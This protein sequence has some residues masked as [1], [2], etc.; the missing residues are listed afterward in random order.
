MKKIYPLIVLLGLVLMGQAVMGQGTLRGRVTDQGS[1]EPLAGAK[2]FLPGGIAGGLSDD[3]G[4]FEFQVPQ[5][6]PFDVIVTFLGYDTLRTNVTDL[7]KPVKLGMREKSV[8]VQAVEIVGRS[9]SEKEQQ[10]P[11]TVES[12]GSI[13][14]KE[15]AGADFYGSLGNLKGV[16]L[17]SASLGF[18]IINTRGFNSTSPV[19]SLQII[20]GVDNQAPGLNFSL[21]NFLGSS[22]LDL[23]KVDLIVGASSAYYGPNAFNGVIS[24]NTKNPF[25]HQGL[26]VQAKVGERA[27]ADVALRYAK[28]FK[29]KND[30]EIFAFKI[31]GAFMRANDWQATNV[32]PTQQSDRGM[33]NP[34]GYDKV[35][36]Y[37]DENLTR[38]INNFS[39]LYAQRRYPGLDIYYRDGYREQDIVNYNTYNVKLSGALHFKVLKGAELVMGSNFGTGSTVYQGDNRYRLEDI[40]F[41]QH[42]IELKKEDKYFIRS[43]FTHEDGG[44]SYDAVTTAFYI[45]DSAKN[46]NDW[47]TDYAYYWITQIK[48]RVKALPGFPDENIFPYDTAAANAVMA[49]YPDS[50]DT[51]HQMARDYANGVTPTTDSRDRFL[52]GTAQFDSVKNYFTSRKFTEGGTRFFDKSKLWHLQGEYKFTPSFMDIVVGGNVRVYLPYSQGTIFSDTGSVRITNKEAGVYLGLEKRLVSDRLKL[53]AT[54]RLDKNQNFNFLV[55]P[56]LSAVY[57]L[58]ADHVLRLALNSA[59]RNP[60]LQDQYL[61]YNVGRAILLGNLNGYDSLLTLESMAAFYEKPVADTLEFFNLDPIRPEKVRT[62]EVGYRGTL[63]DHLYIDASYYYSMYRNFIGYQIAAD[64][65]YI[66]T[67]NGVPVNMLQVNRFYRI[68]TNSQSIVTTQGF[69]IGANWYFK[70]YYMLNGNYSWNVLNKLEVDDPIIPAFN[71]PQHK[72]NVGFGGRNIP[73]TLGKKT[74]RDLGFNFNFKWVQGFQFEGSPQ[75]TGFVPTYWLLDGQVNKKVEKIHTTFKLGASNIL[76]KQVIQVFGGPYVGRMAFLSVLVELDKL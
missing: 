13:A 17:T 52:P 11:L 72:F 46:T 56:A 65:D 63:F 31:N 70:K 23:Q 8:Q 34:G 64:A 19:R 68:A 32:D 21:G 2:V 60:T 39:S 26:S 6:P 3:E 12:M 29:D 44:K 10:A 33:D 75:F 71:T 51:W 9:I 18:K 74:I 49:A 47:S 4:N 38:G 5:A 67:L 48:P 62:V 53:N 25:I 57:Q 59:I 58:N 43:Y 73:V 27:L 54:C 22:E 41:F 37:G 16:D 7:S 20:D 14:I 61:Y 42:K 50:M 45:Q 35:N 30:K 76:N 69:S 40:L 28:A 24:M 15:V 55:S 1:G 36:T 66:D